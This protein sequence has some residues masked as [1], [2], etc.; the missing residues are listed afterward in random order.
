MIE[1]S[2]AE[3]LDSIPQGRNL[4]EFFNNFWI[5]EKENAVLELTSSEGLDDRGSPT[6]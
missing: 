4:R 5:V 6:L 1:R 3:H 2:I